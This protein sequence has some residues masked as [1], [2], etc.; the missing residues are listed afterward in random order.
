L[1]SRWLYYCHPFWWKGLRY[2]PQEWWCYWYQ[3]QLSLWADV[4][5]GW[6]WCLLFIT[7]SVVWWDDFA[8]L[9]LLVLKGLY[10]VKKYS[11]F[12]LLSFLVVKLISV[13]RRYSASFF[14]LLA[15]FS[16]FNFLLSAL[17]FSKRK[18]KSKDFF[19]VSRFSFKAFFCC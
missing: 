15:Y 8:S 2:M 4:P 9:F 18:Q 10:E 16:G 19:S 14:L 12:Q 11:Y 5:H 1:Y 6:Q 3:Y 13:V 17:I 7:N